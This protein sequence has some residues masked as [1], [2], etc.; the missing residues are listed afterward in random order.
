MPVMSLKEIKDSVLALPEGDRSEFFR[1]V[2]A[3]DRDYG[4]VDPEAVS[5]IVTEVWQEEAKFDATKRA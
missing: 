2:R 4:D 3:Q 5:E 1:W